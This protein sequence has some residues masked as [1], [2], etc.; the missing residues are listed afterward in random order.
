MGMSRYVIGYVAWVV[1][2]AVMLVL[3]GLGLTLRGHQWPT[4]SDLFRSASRPTYGRWILFALW[5]WAG[6]HFFIRGWQFFLR[7]RGASEPAGGG[8]GK[9]LTATLTQVVIPL[10]GLFVL[11]GAGVFVS[12]RDAKRGRLPRSRPTA[13]IAKRPRLFARYTGVTVV[14]SYVVFVGAMGLYQLAVGKSAHGIFTSALRYGAFLAFAIAVP[15]FVILSILDAR[16]RRRR[17]D[18]LQNEGR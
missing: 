12:A 8:G 14:S 7:G 18:A 17:G 9:S 6:W 16:V 3:E 11:M 13:L 1:L 2:F 5:L 10:L 4:A 15:T